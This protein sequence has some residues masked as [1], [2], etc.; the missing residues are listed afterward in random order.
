[1]STT[2]EQDHDIT[3]ESL[4]L[5]LA[6]VY[7]LV[8]LV[9]QRRRWL[10][11]V[12]GIGMALTVG[13]AL[14]IPNEYT[15]TAQLMPPDQQALSSTS[16][17]SAALTG[18]A[19][20]LAPS[21][22]GGLMSQRTPGETSIG[23]L[24]S[25][26]TL[27][28]IVNRFDLR[29][30][31]H[32]K[33]FADA[34]KD[35]LSRTTFTE[36]KKSGIIAITVTDRDKARA[37]DIAKAYIEEL[38]N[39]VNSLSTSSAR[40]ERLFLEQRLK[41]IKAELDESSLALSQFSS[42]NATLDLQRQ[43]EATVEAAGKLQGELIAAESEL[44]GLRAIY[45]DDNVRVRE[46]R[47]RIDELQSQL[48]KMSGQGESANSSDLTAGQ[49]LPSIRQLPLLGFTY[50]DLLRQVTIQETLYET[51]TKQYELAKVQEAK[52]IPP[53]KVLDEPDLPEKKSSPHRSIITLIGGLLSALAGVVWVFTHSFWEIVGE[54][55]RSRAFRA[56]LLRSIKDEHVAEG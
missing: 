15:S 9:W 51:L 37:R 41:S 35:L 36:D 7:N 43:G 27:D 8:T 17:L 10:A 55:E 45:A 3:A 11:A 21:V 2:Q 38:D 54:S 32:D 53:I 6:P 19:G 1:L 22:S 31:Y 23:I 29:R 13:I 49:M 46:V 14:L 33:L 30:V 40:R 20:L 34:R 50:Y 47:G 56:A 18:A 28:E 5:T 42:R 39:L 48:R 16:M 4:G 25:R 12:V 44:S 52:E 24:S 26:T